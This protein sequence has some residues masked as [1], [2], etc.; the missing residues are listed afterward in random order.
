MKRKAMASPDPATF[1]Q[2]VH[3][4][5]PVLLIELSRL[6][7]TLAWVFLSIPVHAAELRIPQRTRSHCPEVKRTNDPTDFFQL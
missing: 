4:E 5:R 6:I 1:G 2:A 7:P 3:L